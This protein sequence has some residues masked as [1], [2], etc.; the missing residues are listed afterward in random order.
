MPQAF[1]N[2]ILILNR[3][4]ITIPEEFH[5]TH[6]KLSMERTKLSNLWIDEHYVGKSHL[7]Q[8][9]QCFDISKYLSVCLD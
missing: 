8:S 5:D 9:P 6:I 3:K 2:S 7:L 4:E 1:K